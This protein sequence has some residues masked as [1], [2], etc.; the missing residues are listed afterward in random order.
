MATNSV[1]EELKTYTLKRGARLWPGGTTG[2]RKVGGDRVDLTLRQAIAF[3]DQLVEKPIVDAGGAPIPA[4]VDGGDPEQT[5]AWQA[6][7]ENQQAPPPPPATGPHPIHDL[8]A[9]DASGLVETQT[10]LSELDL[11]QQAEARNPKH[12]GGRTTVNRA[13]DARR[14]QLKDQ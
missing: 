13:I 12:P 9:I 4:E 3:R 14:Q 2:V 5:G 10:T 11:L 1:G 7:Q 6:G 8:N